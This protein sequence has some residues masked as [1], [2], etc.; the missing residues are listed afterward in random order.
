MLCINPTLYSVDVESFRLEGYGML[1]PVVGK[2]M[3]LLY[4]DDL[5]IFSSSQSKLDRVMK[6]TKRAMEDIGLVWDEKKCSVVHVKCSSLSSDQ[7]DTVGDTRIIKALK[8]GDS[9]KFLGELENAKQEN[10]LVLYGASKVYLQR[11]SLIW[12][13]RLLDYH[14]K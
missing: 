1:R 12:T 3:H 14:K 10:E 2:I 9:Y 13:T 11:L 4:I 7:G 5:K 6:A 8:E